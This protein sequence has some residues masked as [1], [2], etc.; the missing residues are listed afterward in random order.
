MGPGLSGLG[1]PHRPP[2]TRP[3]PPPSA[4]R[5]HRWPRTCPGN[6]AA[7][8]AGPFREAEAGGGRAGPGAERGEQRGSARPPRRGIPGAHPATAAA[9]PS[10]ARGGVPY[11]T[12]LPPPP[13][14]RDPLPTAGPDL[15]APPAAVRHVG[16]RGAGGRAG[17]AGGG[18]GAAAG[19]GGPAPPAHVLSLSRPRRYCRSGPG[20]R[21]GAP[22]AA[23]LPAR[24]A[25]RQGKGW[26]RGMGGTAVVL[27]GAVGWGLRSPGPHG[28]TFPG[29]AGMGFW[30]HC[31]ISHPVGR[32]IMR[33]DWGEGGLGITP[34]PSAPSPPPP[35]GA[36]GPP[37]P[38]CLCGAPQYGFS[39]ECCEAI[40]ALVWALQPWGGAVI[41]WLPPI[42][43]PPPPHFAL[44]SH[45]GGWLSRGWTEAVGHPHFSLTAT[46]PAP[47]H[48]SAPHCDRP[49][50]PL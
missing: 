43:L 36:A 7:G 32:R 13:T 28:C 35:S 33:W 6:A 25:L 47:Q 26:G 31:G 37:E 5:Q 46:P 4:R 27:G 24:P 41:R 44:S 11:P 42:A 3:G 45:K 15:P 10:S 8:R 50:A 23:R 49:V 39:P 18:A 14:P 1:R 9:F 19:R 2:P 40:G 21:H 38:H 22:A 34:L 29:A 30:G 20:L 12:P 48:S 16:P 17:G